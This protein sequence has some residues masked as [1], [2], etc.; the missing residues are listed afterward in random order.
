MRI[1][2]ETS[3]YDIID[4]MR[5]PQGASVQEVCA[6]LG[7]QRTTFYRYQTK[8]TA[9]GIPFYEKGDYSGNTNSKRW[10]IDEADYAK[11]IPV[12]FDHTERMMLR[13]ILGRTRL[14][15]KT[16]LKPRMETLRA[17]LNAALLHDRVKPISTTLYSFKGSISYEGKEDIIERLFSLIEERRTGTVTYRAALKSEAKTYD[18][19][20]LTLV[21]HA[22]ALYVI[23]AIPKHERNIRILAVD[24]IEALKATEKQFEIPVGFNPE[25][26]LTPSFGIVVEEPIRVKVRFTGD[27]AFYARE[28]TWG[29]EQTIEES[30]AGTIVLS[31]TASGSEEIA[32]WILSWGADAR[33]LEPES[34][35]VKVK[36]ELAGAL[37][38]Y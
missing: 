18:I 29:Q 15:D 17:K 31:F 33:V 1:D 37:A 21:D 3:L 32:A 16:K 14:F 5:R 28:R 6:T 25:T 38:G 12:R 24:R 30:D 36:A 9:F 2:A 11:S 22:N 19:E 27:A 10:Y 35:V 13:T 26:Y 20:P 4:L 7:C 34:L 8:L 23:V